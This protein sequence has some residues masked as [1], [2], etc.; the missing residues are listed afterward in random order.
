M[1]NLGVPGKKNKFK[2][3]CN[4]AGLL[5]SSLSFNVVDSPNEKL[6]GSSHCREWLFPSPESLL[7]ST[8]DWAS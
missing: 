7:R 8:E 3:C 5:T 2:F 4:H 1:W 6:K